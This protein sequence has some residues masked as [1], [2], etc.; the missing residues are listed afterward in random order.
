MQRSL[1]V[2]LGIEGEVETGL[3][4]RQGKQFALAGLSSIKRM[5]GYV[6]IYIW[7]HQQGM[8]RTR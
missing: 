8:C 3:R 5:E 1:R 2:V 7:E 4:Q 6:A